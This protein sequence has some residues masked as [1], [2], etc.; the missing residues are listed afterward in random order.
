MAEP[1]VVVGAG[2][3][4]REVIDVVEAMNAAS[5]TPVFEVIQM[6]FDIGHFCSLFHPIYIAPKS[7]PS[8]GLM[9][10]TKYGRVRT[11]IGPGPS[12]GR[13]FS[14]QGVLET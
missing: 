9:M 3:F 6:L 13:R 12:P 10:P 7:I 4:G 2:G 5:A 11:E 1:L 8:E 14:Y